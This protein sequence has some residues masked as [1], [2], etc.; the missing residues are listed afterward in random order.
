[1]ARKAEKEAKDMKIKL[2]GKQPRILGNEEAI[3][4]GKGSSF[5][6]NKNIG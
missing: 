4:H 5:G 1:M 3:L 2:K 6:D